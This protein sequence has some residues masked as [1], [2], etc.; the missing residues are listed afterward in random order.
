MAEAAVAPGLDMLAGVNAHNTALA[1]LEALE[2]QI[3]AALNRRK[4]NGLVRRAIKVWRRGEI[5]RA[6][7]LALQ[8]AEAD[9]TN[10]QAYH[11]LALALEKMGHLHK[12]LVTFERAFALA[13]N[14]PD[15]LLN[16]GLTAWNMKLREQAV[17]MFRLY[18]T[19]S[20]DS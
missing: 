17:K 13:P 5:A 16:L 15:L 1:K 12:A 8:A 19:A 6:G 3:D 10:A 14:E 7:Q 9:E 11:V 2:E 20:P 4:S 18:I